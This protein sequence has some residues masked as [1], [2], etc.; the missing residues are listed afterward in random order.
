MS[1]N[2]FEIDRTKLLV[3]L[4]MQTPI[5][6]VAVAGSPR[7]DKEITAKDLK[8][9]LDQKKEDRQMVDLRRKYKIIEN[10]IYVRTQM[11]RCNEGGISEWNALCYRSEEQ[12]TSCRQRYH[13]RPSG[14]QL[15]PSREERRRR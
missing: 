8:E 7:S 6:E 4:I 5:K 13:G 3:H 10:I 11:E 1:A 15:F 14:F 12:L 9:A 2:L